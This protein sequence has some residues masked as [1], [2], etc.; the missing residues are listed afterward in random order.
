MN[1]GVSLPGANV[2]YAVRYLIDAESS[3]TLS[4]MAGVGSYTPAVAATL[5]VDPSGDNNAILFTAD[6]LGEVGNDI[7]VEYATPAV[8]AATTVAVV[9]DAIT[10][11]PGTKARMVVSGTPSLTLAGT[12]EFQSGGAFPNPAY[13]RWVEMSLL[14]EIWWNT[15]LARWE[16]R[17]NPF[18]TE[19]YYSTSMT[20]TPDLATGWTAYGSPLPTGSPTITAAVSTAAQVIAAVN[21]SSEAPVTASIAPGNDGSGGVTAMTAANMTLG[22]GG[23]IGE[24]GTT[25]HE[26]NAIPSLASVQGILIQVA[27]GTGTITGTGADS[28]TYADGQVITLIR[29][30]GIA[31]DFADTLT[32]TADTATDITISVI[33]TAA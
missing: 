18:A 15:A 8:S 2:A 1:T 22:A 11:T 10:V 13:D 28:I 32:I 6:A 29:P 31:T 25:D 12:Y 33:G 16:I 9:G 24:G 26:G 7:S 19:G 5:T 27:S 4:V 17:T 30:D 23:T 3:E 21:A 20:A 14:S